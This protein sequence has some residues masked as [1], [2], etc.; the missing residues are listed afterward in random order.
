M[1]RYRV[2]DTNVLVVANGRDTHADAACQLACLRLLIDSRE[3]AILILD[4]LGLI[5]REYR[6]VLRP[7]GEP[8]SGDAFF[9]Y[10]LDFQFSGAHCL[11]ANIS[12]DRATD[13]IDQFPKDADLI[14]FDRDD[15]KFVAAA[16]ASG[17]RCSIQN[18]VDTDWRDYLTPLTRNGL[19]IRQLCP[20]HM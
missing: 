4:S 10:L 12:V 6:N 14:G 2:V 19:C 13:E 1:T 7:T 11:I 20:Q 8:G 5:L 18:A 3:N 9:K 17:V 16:I 15:R